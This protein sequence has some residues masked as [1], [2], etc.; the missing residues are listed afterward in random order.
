MRLY[1]DVYLLNPKNPN[2]GKVFIQLG[3]IYDKDI[4]QWVKITQE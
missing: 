4:D 3:G 2:E 1:V